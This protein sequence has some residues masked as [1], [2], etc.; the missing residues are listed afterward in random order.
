MC[1]QPWSLASAGRRPQVLPRHSLSGDPPVPACLARKAACPARP[2]C[3]QCT[4]PL[5]PKALNVSFL[6]LCFPWPLVVVG[7][8][9]AGALNWVP[10]TPRSR[11][12]QLSFLRSGDTWVWPQWSGAG[13]RSPPTR[14]GCPHTGRLGGRGLRQPTWGLP[15][16]RCGSG[17]RAESG[18]HSPRRW[19]ALTLRLPW[20]AGMAGSAPRTGCSIESPC[21]PE[22]QIGR[23]AHASGGLRD[24]G[25][26]GGHPISVWP[27]PA[28]PR[29]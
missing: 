4:F 8:A 26:S 24:S 3:L 20:G 28:S 22:I 19:P 29:G 5:S 7:H 17:P 23:Q 16:R 27:Q 13:G 25:P 9:Q 18:S 21:L 12:G 10:P 6:P 15:P 11:W 14:P 1:L 2:C